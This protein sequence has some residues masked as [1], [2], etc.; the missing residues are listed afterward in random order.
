[1]FR[2]L[3]LPPIVAMIQGIEIGSD[4]YCCLIIVL[5][6]FTYGYLGSLTVIL[7]NEMHSQDESDKKM[8]AGG[9]TGFFLNFGLVVGATLSILF[10]GRGWL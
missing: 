8:I 1:M 5:Y 6:A 2:L 7:V 3:L 9:F 4:W 10:A